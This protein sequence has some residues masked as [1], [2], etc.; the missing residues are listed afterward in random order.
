MIKAIAFDCGN[1]LFSN[2]WNDENTDPSFNIIHERLGMTKEKGDKIFL[3]HWPE[4]SV[5]KKSEDVFF[6]D[7]IDVS[8]EKISLEELKR[9]YYSCILKKDVFEIVERLYEKY[10]DLPLYTLN[11]EGREWMDARIKKFNLRKYF[12][13]FITSGYVGYTKKMGRR[14]FDI[15]LERTGL[16]PEECLFIDDRKNFVTLAKEIGYKAIL[17]DNKSRL[18]MDLA[19]Y[20]FNL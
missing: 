18:I 14:I 9:L 7:L 12:R 4:I 3:K 17:Y 8:K 13:D 16:N 20:G 2:A 6:Q 5:G 1:V 19:N 15:F 10:P 11:D